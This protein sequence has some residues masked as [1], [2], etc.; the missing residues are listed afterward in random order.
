MH[1]QALSLHITVLMLT[2]YT[3]EEEEACTGAVFTYYCTHAHIVHF[4]Q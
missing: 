1:A 3:Y 2:Q 4:T